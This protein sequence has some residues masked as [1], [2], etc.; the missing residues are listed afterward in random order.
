E[1][2]PFRVTRNVEVELE[3]DEAVDSFTDLVAEELRQRRLEDPVRLEHAAGA[4]RALLTL[5]SSKLKLTEADLY[6]MAAEVDYSG[7]WG[8]V[9]LNRPDLHDPPW[10]PVAPAALGDE[11]D[12][13]FALIR[14]G[15]VLVHHPYESFDASVA[16]F[17]RAAADDPK[18]Q[19][20]K[21]TVYRI[22]SDTPFIDDLIPAARAGQQGAG[23]VGVTARFGE[24]QNLQGAQKLDPVGRHVLYR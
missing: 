24:Q 15:D 11:D 20:V 19:A 22:G 14:K 21:M 10:Q 13:L 9:A 7:L 6:P 5:L 17:I 2:V 4:S 1:V 16:R 3:E 18:V 12:D 8:L 23:L